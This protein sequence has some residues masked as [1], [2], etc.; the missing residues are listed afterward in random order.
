MNTPLTTLSPVLG[1]SR[2]LWHRARR[3]H[4][5]DPW[6]IA[7]GF[8]GDPAPTCRTC[9]KRAVMADIR[10]SQRPWGRGF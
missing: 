9:L 3:G 6:L 10:D 8:D 7:F 4:Y 5:P 1:R 2:G